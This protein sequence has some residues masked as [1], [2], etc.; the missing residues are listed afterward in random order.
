MQD[1]IAAIRAAHRERCF[2]MEQRKRADLSLLSFL[3]TQAGWRLDLPEAERKAIAERAKAFADG[4]E[5]E[6]L[7]QWRPVVE[8]SIGAR[9][10]FEAVEKAALKR[11]E[12]SAEQLPV[13][14]AFGKAIRGFGP[15][16]LA[17][18][19]G[20]AGDLSIYANPAKLWKR[21]GVGIVD[22][23]RQGGL[24]KNASKEDWITH[25]YNRQRRSRMWNIGDAMIKSN[26]DGEY[27]TLYLARKEYEVARDPEMKPIHAH[28][29]AQRVMEKRLLRNLWTAWRQTIDG[30]KPGGQMS[31]APH[32]DQQASLEPS[33]TNRMPAERRAN[34]CSSPNTGMPDA[35]NPNQQAQTA[36]QPKGRM[37]AAA[38][39]HGTIGPQTSSAGRSPSNS[40]AKHVLPPTAS[41]PRK[42]R[43]IVSPQPETPVP[44]APIQDTIAETQPSRVLS[45]D[46]SGHPSGVTQTSTATRSHSI[47]ETLPP[48][49]P[50]AATSPDARG[51]TAGDTHTSRAPRSLSRA[52]GTGDRQGRPATQNGTAITR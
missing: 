5:D 37:L 34:S 40:E 13:W 27:R 41:A 28:R 22:G 31:A 8:A 15:A 45:P 23:I 18:I 48:A 26:R 46:A 42:R 44:G 4:G 3:R 39:G 16:S 9:A 49:K 12:E 10:P 17:V 24:A 19:V 1:I 29:R 25:G 32:S 11:M 51:H 52:N 21:M 30:L 35:S 43:A 20:E 6:G 33:P 7:A 38:T 47:Q 50:I 14:E 2:A 36:V